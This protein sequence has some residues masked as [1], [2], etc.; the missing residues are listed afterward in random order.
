[1]NEW[2]SAHGI[3]K[4]VPAL[5]GGTILL[6]SFRGGE[7]KKKDMWKEEFM[8]K[9]EERSKRRVW[10]FQGDHKEETH[11]YVERESY[12]KDQVLWICVVMETLYNIYAFERVKDF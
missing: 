10:K 8:K 6:G 9:G 1:M 2:L 5:S 4:H 11:Q 12:T 7:N 3:G